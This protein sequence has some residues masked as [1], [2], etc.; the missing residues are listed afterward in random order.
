MQ[1]KQQFDGHRHGN[2]HSGSHQVS[3]R[4]LRLLEEVQDQG[5]IV[6]YHMYMVLYPCVYHVHPVKLYFPPLF[7]DIFRRSGHQFFN[8]ISRPDA[9][10]FVRSHFGRIIA[11]A[12]WSNIGKTISFSE[13]GITDSTSWDISEPAIGCLQGISVAR[14]HQ[15]D[16]A[17][18]QWSSQHY[19]AWHRDRHRWPSLRESICA[20]IFWRKNMTIFH[21]PSCSR[22]GKGS[23][24]TRPTR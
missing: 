2:T 17:H 18:H 19:A 8:C 20:F 23:S 1:Y 15:F 9:I 13:H 10:N 24:S 5:I 7:R 16:A 3:H 4:E 21:S 22:T 6:K 11:E 14:G 12:C